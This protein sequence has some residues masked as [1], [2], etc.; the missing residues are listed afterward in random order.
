[1]LKHYF[2]TAVRNL[3]K[4]KVF[5]SINVVGLSVSIAIFLSLVSY[6]VYQFSYDTF[7]PDAGRIYRVNYIEYQ[8]D[9]PVIETARSHSRTAL[10]MHEYL[11]QAEAVCRLYHEKAYIWNEDVKLVDQDMMFADSSFFKVFG[12]RLMEGDVNN[13]LVAPNSVVI[14]QSQAAVY[15]PG[16][17]AM[18]KTIFFNEQLPVTIT[19][20]F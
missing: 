9:Q 16:E 18:G 20:I 4:N 12:V 6:V 17:E 10:L 3:F 1:M 11:P 19:G 2:I 15:F 7:Y 13:A 14:S 5:T 8:E